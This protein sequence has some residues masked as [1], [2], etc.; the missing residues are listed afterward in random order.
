MYGGDYVHV[1]RTHL[2][3]KWYYTAV[4]G[5]QLMFQNSVFVQSHTHSCYTVFFSLSLGSTLSSMFLGILLELLLATGQCSFANA[6]YVTCYLCDG[7]AIPYPY[8]TVPLVDSTGT[9]SMYTC[10][11]VANYGLNGAYTAET[12]DAIK[13]A[14]APTCGCP[15]QAPSPY[16]A[17]P[18]APSASPRFPTAPFPYRVPSSAPFRYPTSPSTPPPSSG[19]GAIV[20]PIIAGLAL[21]GLGKVIYQCVFHNNG[22]CNVF[23][24]NFRT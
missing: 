1:T 5:L 16:Q 3:E 17:T 7:S 13:Q 8:N 4:G 12:C 20:G 2:M 22:T 18:T 9:T 19:L 24:F 23:N 14:V 6:Y 11:D 15:Y 21:L 10:L